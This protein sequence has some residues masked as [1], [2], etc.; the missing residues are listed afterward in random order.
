MEWLSSLKGK[1]VGLDASSLIYYIEEHPAFL[2]LV[3]PF[4]NAMMRGDFEV[5]TSTVTITEVLVH[6]I[7]LNNYA[8]AEAYRDILQNAAY[9][10]TVPVTAGIAETAA[11]LRAVHNIRT[12]DAIHIATAMH[13]NAEFFFTNDTRL[14]VVS[15]PTM[16]ILSDLAR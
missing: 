12:P 6:P 16:L 11:R 7:S 13:C 10:R 4:F 1:T 15:R 8:L 5:V 3:D 9:L 14:A 2:L